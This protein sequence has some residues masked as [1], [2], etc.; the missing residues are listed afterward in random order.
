MTST[1]DRYDLVILGSGSTAFARGTGR[2]A[3]LLVQSGTQAKETQQ[4]FQD[5]EK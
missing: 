2:E 5:G 4:R 1:Q 3:S